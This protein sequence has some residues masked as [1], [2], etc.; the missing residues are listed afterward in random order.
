MILSDFVM[1]A[2]TA[3]GCFPLALPRGRRARGQL[4]SR[5]I[6]TKLVGTLRIVCLISTSGQ[7]KSKGKK[8]LKLL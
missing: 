5:I 4:P 7:V 3:Q 8:G 1:T 6:G 2:A